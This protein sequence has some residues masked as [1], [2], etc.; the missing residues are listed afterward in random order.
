MIAASYSAETE[1]QLLLLAEI[2]YIYKRIQ[3]KMQRCS[4]TILG[5]VRI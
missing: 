4:K 2:T 1:R 3:H 5:Y